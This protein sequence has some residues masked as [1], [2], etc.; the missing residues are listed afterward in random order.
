[1][2]AGVIGA[3][4]RG[5]RGDVIFNIKIINIRDFA[6]TKYK[7]VDDTPYGGGPGMVMRADILENALLTGVVVAGKYG[8]NFKERLNVICPS[9][10]GQV[11]NNVEAKK[12]ALKIKEEKDLVFICGRYEGIDERFLDKYV[13]QFISMGDFVLSGGELAVMTIIDSSMRFV[14]GVLLN[15]D[16]SVQDSFEDGLLECPQY[17]KPQEFSGVKVPEV[18]MNGN[19][20]KI[21]EYQLDEKIKMT[22][23][24]RPDLYINHKKAEKND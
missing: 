7:S 21:V 6:M 10:R 4:L 18:L 19:H 9:P 15:Q 2:S 24:Y 3:A 14:P 1:M 8:E 22:K 11:W 17:T 16:S 5:E 13:D 23:K 20:K 12:M